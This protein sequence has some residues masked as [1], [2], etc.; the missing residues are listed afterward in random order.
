MSDIDVKIQWHSP[1]QVFAAVFVR[2]GAEWH[3]DGALVGLSS[4]PSIAVDELIGLACYLVVEGENFL[5]DGP[6]TLS[7]RLWLFRLLDQGTIAN[8]EMYAAV[9]KATGG[10]DPYSPELVS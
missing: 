10:R 3:L 4:R 5:T 1:D 7:D 6:I 9:R 8:D 2:D